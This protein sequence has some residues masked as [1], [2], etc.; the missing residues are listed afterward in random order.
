MRSHRFTLIAVIVGA[1]ALALCIGACPAS[2]TTGTWIITTSTTLTEDHQGPVVIG[3][4]QTT[5]NCSG[6]TI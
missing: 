1:G 3:A 5:L 4:E 6:H 2:A